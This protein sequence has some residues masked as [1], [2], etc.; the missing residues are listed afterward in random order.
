M[1]FVCKNAGAILKRRD[2]S[3]SILRDGSAK[4][5]SFMHSLS[6]NKGGPVTLRPGYNTVVVEAAAGP[7]GR[8][9]VRC[10]PSHCGS[11]LRLMA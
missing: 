4:K 8:W 10:D 6:R 2:S 7:V 1:R 3:G 11:K 5:G 9:A